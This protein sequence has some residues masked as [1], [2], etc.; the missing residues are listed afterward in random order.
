[1]GGRRWVVVGRLRSIIGSGN[2]LQAGPKT[3]KQ[4][5]PESSRKEGV[6]KNTSV[7]GS[8]WVQDVAQR[9]VVVGCLVNHWI[10]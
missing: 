9:L 6:C 2:T 4:T 1:V 8:R 3:E 7:A 5:K 10:S